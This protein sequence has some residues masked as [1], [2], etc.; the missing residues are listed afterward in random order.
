MPPRGPQR[1][2]TK[3]AIS[4]RLEREAVAVYRATGRG[5]QSRLSADVSAA[6]KRRARRAG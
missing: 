5:W 1:R 3:V 6:A 4:L 2:P